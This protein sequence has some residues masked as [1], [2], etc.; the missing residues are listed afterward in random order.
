MALS[1]KTGVVGNDAGEVA[2]DGEANPGTLSTF[3][4]LLNWTVCN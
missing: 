2:A 3:E 4:E 1:I